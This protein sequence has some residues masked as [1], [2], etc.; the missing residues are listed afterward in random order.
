MLCHSVGAEVN[1]NR[2]CVVFKNPMVTD[3]GLLLS[4]KKEWRVAT[5][6]T[7]CVFWVEEFPPLRVQILKSLG[8]I[9]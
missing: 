3:S 8:G 9:F 4:H 1:G 7:Q 6:A 2:S 5:E